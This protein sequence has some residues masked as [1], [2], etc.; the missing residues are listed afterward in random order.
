MGLQGMF[1]VGG[2]LRAFVRI[3]IYRI[4]EIFRISFR[5]ACVFAVTMN[6][7][8]PN[9]DKRLP[10]TDTRAGRILKIL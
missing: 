8:N 4:S 1:G 10:S 3:R 2:Q 5:Q 7:A 9:M 6:P